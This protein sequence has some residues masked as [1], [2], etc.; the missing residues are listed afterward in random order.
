MEIDLNE[1]AMETLTEFNRII[2]DD[3]QIPDAVFGEFGTAMFEVAVLEMSSAAKLKKG[4]P[5]AGDKRHSEKLTLARARFESLCIGAPHVTR[6]CLEDLSL[7]YGVLSMMF[8]DATS[9]LDVNL[10]ASLLM[11]VSTIKGM[12]LAHGRKGD[13]QQPLATGQDL[14][15]AVMSKLG[16]KGAQARHAPNRAR[17]AKWEDWY[18]QNKGRYKSLE[19]AAGKVVV[20]VEL[21][22]SQQKMLK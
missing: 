3:L 6:A 14:A 21:F 16:L 13:A 15:K 2:E 22:I 1:L 11:L 4:A 10:G 17:K 8:D 5:I 20:P 12:V 9:K 19:Q 18:R 7:G